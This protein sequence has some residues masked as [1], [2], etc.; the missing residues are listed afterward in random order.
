MCTA[1][2]AFLFFKKKKTDDDT[3]RNDMASI[4][5]TVLSHCV[6]R[7]IIGLLVALVG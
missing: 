6:Y 4:A 7:I 5:D 1:G 2:V 3:V